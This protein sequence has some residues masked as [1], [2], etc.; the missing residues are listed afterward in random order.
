MKDVIVVGAGPGGLTAACYLGRFRRPTLVLDA[1]ESRARWIPTSHNTPGFPDGVGGVEL[2]RRSRAQARRYGAEIRSGT[3]R[4]IARIDGGFSLDLAGGVERCRY[5]ILATGVRDRLP[6]LDNVEYAMNRTVLR[7]CPVCDAYEAIGKR[8]AVIG[9]GAHALR[10][11]EFLRTYSDDVTLINSDFVR[12]GDMVGELKTAGI[13][14]VYAALTDLS[15]GPEALTVRDRDGH[16]HRYEV[17]Y[18]ALGCDPRN[19]LAAHVG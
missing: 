17:A 12:D 14:L 16:T 8:V 6:P 2:L 18:S 5:L 19:D 1:G 11:A 3:V 4:S 15:L 10:E 13:R 9:A 7:I